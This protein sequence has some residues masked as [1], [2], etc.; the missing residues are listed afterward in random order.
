MQ[1]SKPSCAVVTLSIGEEFAEL[2]EVTTPF[3][4]DYA[5]RVNADFRII[6]DRGD[7]HSRFAKFRIHDLLDEYERILFIDND[8]LIL[9]HAPNVFE[10]VP[11]DAVGAVLV[12]EYNDKHDKNIRL[13]EEHLGEV[14]LGR[15]CWNSGVMVVSRA[16]REIFRTDVPEF[17]DYVKLRES[18]DFFMYYDQNILNYRTR[19][20]GFAVHDMGYRW[21]HTRGVGRSAQ[22]FNSYII[23]Y[24]GRGHRQGNRLRQ[25][26]VDAAILRRRALQ[27]VFAK[28]PPVTW[29]FDRVL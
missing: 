29:A 3:M 5:R 6:T 10:E 24:A 1:L 16:H 25:I 17:Q 2:S 20:L 28:M 21:N 14:G 13:T 9:P 7:L 12:S 22:R 18:V 23:H 26:K 27:E 19:Q 8:A 11:A 15:S 4:A